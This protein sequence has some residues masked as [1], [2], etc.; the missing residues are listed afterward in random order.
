M[1]RDQLGVEPI[2]Q[3]L[4]V[5]ASAYYQRAT[6]ERSA[7]ALADERL[8][9]RIRDVHDKNYECYGYRRVHA[10]LVR[11]GEQ[12]GRDQVAR[13]MRSAG[14]EGAKLGSVESSYAKPG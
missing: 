3:T 1:H 5:S 9:G 7:R 11:D 10:Q 13:L 6:G 2:C 4:D 8:T 12:A 14:I